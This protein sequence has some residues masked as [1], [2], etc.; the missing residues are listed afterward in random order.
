MMGSIAAAWLPGVIRHRDVVHSHVV[1]TL[2]AIL[3][4]S[5]RRATTWGI[6]YFYSFLFPSAALMPLEYCLP[7]MDTADVV[8]DLDFVSSYREYVV[9]RTGVELMIEL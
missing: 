1:V 4:H 7:L 8:E 9:D 5:A 2:W 6:S 3:H